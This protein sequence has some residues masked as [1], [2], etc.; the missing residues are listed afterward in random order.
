MITPYEES[1]ADGRTGPHSVRGD[2]DGAK[3][4]R[5]KKGDNFADLKDFRERKAI[6]DAHRAPPLVKIPLKVEGALFGFDR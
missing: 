6:R 1:K 2:S 3:K 5:R 4:R